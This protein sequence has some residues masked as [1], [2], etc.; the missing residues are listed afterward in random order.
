M[1]NDND[2]ANLPG[3]DF[4]PPLEAALRRTDS[5]KSWTPSQGGS[6]GSSQGSSQVMMSFFTF[7]FY[8]DSVSF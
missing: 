5:N 7:T 3:D 6:Q 1:S 8:P 2:N 4:S